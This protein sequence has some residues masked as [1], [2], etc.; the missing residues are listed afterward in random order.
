MKFWDKIVDSR[1]SERFSSDRE[2]GYGFDNYHPAIIAS[3]V[4]FL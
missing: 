1:L 3:N 2:G 4:N